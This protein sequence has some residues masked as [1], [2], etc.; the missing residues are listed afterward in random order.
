M[1]S[2]GPFLSPTEAARRLGVSSKALRIY[3]EHALVTPGRTAAGW[4]AYGPEEMRRAGEVVALRD[5]GF[6]LAQ[7]RRVLDGET[8]DLEPALASHL[9]RLEVEL[10]LVADRVRRVRDLCEAAAAGQAPSITELTKAAS[11]AETL[12]CAF[13]LP[14][15]WGGERFELTRRAALTWIIGPLGSGK[16]RLARAL[17]GNIPG[18]RFLPMERLDEARPEMPAALAARVEAAT[19]WLVEDG[20]TESPAL[21][22]LIAALEDDGPT[23]VV[24]DMVEHG[25]DEA[26]ERALAVHLRRRALGAAPL[27]LMTRSSATLDLEAMTADEAILYCPPN[28]G[29]P[30][31][32]A[33]R[34]GAPGYDAVADCLAAPQVRARTAGMV[35][36]LPE[37]AA[38]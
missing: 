14:W 6:S 18:A 24:V 20:A 10:G 28:H 15:P 31:L 2:S 17:A 38:G 13:D 35:A 4:R 8:D 23:A 22:L 7:V 32:V 37:R 1:P 26:T 34:P 9:M 29:P 16:T 30:V 27:F 11:A 12:V 3:E 5:L 21:A 25:L 19:L 36:W 33:P